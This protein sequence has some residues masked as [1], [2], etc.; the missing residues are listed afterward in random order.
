MSLG[1]GVTVPARAEPHAAIA[2]L[3]RA[4]AVKAHSGSAV[5][6]GGGAIV[7][8][9]GVGSEGHGPGEVGTI[10]ATWRVLLNRLRGVAFLVAAG[11]EPSHSKAPAV[12]SFVLC[13]I[14]V[15]GWGAQGR[16]GAVGVRAAL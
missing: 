14:Q 16:S 13:Y 2:R 15:S 12:I 8:G 6:P 9:G 1:G 3:S 7:G 10:T 11:G 4:D 5:R